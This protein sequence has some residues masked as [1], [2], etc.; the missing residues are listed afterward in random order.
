MENSNARARLVAR[1]LFA[2]CAAMFLSGITALPFLLATDEKPL[3]GLFASLVL[4]LLIAAIWLGR[5]SEADLI[6]RAARLL[7]PPRDALLS[8]SLLAVWLALGLLGLF[9]LVEGVSKPLSILGGVLVFWAILWLMLL[10]ALYWGA[11]SNGMRLAQ[12]LFTAIGVVV[13][14][15]LLAEGALRLF[16]ALAPE[17]AP[18]VSDV[19]TEPQTWTTIT[20]TYVEWAEQYWREYGLASR[21]IVWTPYVYWRMRPFDGQYVNVDARGVRYT[22]PPAQPP[23][24]TIHVYGGSTVW[25]HGARD[26]HTIPAE[27]MRALGERGV[28]A[29]V[30]N[31][32]EIGYI[33][34]QDAAL[35]D[36]QLSIGNVPAVAVFYWGFNDINITYTDGYVGVSGAEK[37]RGAQFEGAQCIVDLSV[38]VLLNSL[39]YKTHLGTRLLRR[40]D[41]L[42]VNPAEGC[43]LGTEDWSN[44]NAALVAQ[45]T[46]DPQAV[47]QNILHMTRYVRGLA[48]AYGVQVIFVWQPAIWQKDPL[49]WYEQQIVAQERWRVFGEYYNQ[50]DAQIR[51]LFAED[52]E[53]LIWTD[54]FKDVDPSINIFIDKIHIT[55]EGNALVGAALADAVLERR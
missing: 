32:G 22:P 1:S 24:M 51:A 27:L 48:Q 25:G 28:A 44:V 31:F 54:F 34:R 21:E 52:P 7:T 39:L 5:Q 2:L 11:V 49:S 17:D 35:F 45:Q 3:N 38:P 10:A 33:S 6:E 9:W 4:I 8:G 15:L 20:D 12:P 42:P 47:A 29:A 53:M 16:D 55:E 19:D 23:Q 41:I 50:V 18:R 46:Q 36:L 14:F 37:N 40:L 26:D 30:T 13:V 43:A